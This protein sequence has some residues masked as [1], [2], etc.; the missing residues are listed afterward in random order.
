MP[1]YV[2]Q[3]TKCNS[4]TEEI[5]KFTDPPLTVCNICNGLLE[6]QTAQKGAFHLKGRGWYKDQYV[7]PYGQ[8]VK[9]FEDTTLDKSAQDMGFDQGMRDDLKE[10]IEYHPDPI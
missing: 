6:K 5:Q 1:I 10:Q 7:N 3:C 9:T 2:Y 8:G 4:K